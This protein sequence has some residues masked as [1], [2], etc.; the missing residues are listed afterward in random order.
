[1][2]QGRIVSLCYSNFVIG[3]RHS[4][5]IYTE[6]TRFAPLGSDAT[7]AY[8]Y[9]D[10]RFRN[11]LPF[12]ISLRFE[13]G[14]DTLSGSVCAPVPL[15]PCTVEFSVEEEADARRVTT[16]RQ[17]PGARERDCLGT[18]RYGKPRDVA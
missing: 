3:N 18:S 15:E 9:K 1:M 5:D 17:R 11:V 10:L 2:A 13:L 14:E 8:G 7:V 16:W 4:V 6:Q 12:P